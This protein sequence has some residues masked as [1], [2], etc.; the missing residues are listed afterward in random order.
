MFAIGISRVHDLEDGHMPYHSCACIRPREQPIKPRWLIK[1]SWGLFCRTIWH[2]GAWFS[3]K[4]EMYQQRFPPICDLVGVPESRSKKD[5]VEH[6]A[7]TEH[8][9]S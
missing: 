2:Y 3:N 9:V 4:D 6:E 1:D 7:L 8:W 5:S